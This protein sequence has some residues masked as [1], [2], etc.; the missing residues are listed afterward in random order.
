MKYL[1][2]IFHLFV[3]AGCTVEVPDYVSAESGES[4][5]WINGYGDTTE[6]FSV[7]V[8]YS[9]G[10]V[11]AS[12]AMYQD[13]A[14]MDS[15]LD[16]NVSIKEFSEENSEITFTYGQF[17]GS[18]KEYRYGVNYAAVRDS[19]IMDCDSMR[20]DQIS[21]NTQKGYSV[22]EENLP[23]TIELWYTVTTTT[24]KASGTVQFKKIIREQE[25][26]MRIH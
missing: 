1:I 19:V 3:F 5:Q 24:G 26:T 4:S 16:V 2:A 12:V 21:F 18:L 13:P 11:Y 20:F 6:D 7:H 22:A 23:E 14:K 17:P 9:Q 10:L 25:Q 15:I 8:V